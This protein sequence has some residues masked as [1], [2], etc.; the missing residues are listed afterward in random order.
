MAYTATHRHCRIAPRKVRLVID[1]IRGLDVASAMARL[2]FSPRRG[3]AQSP[4]QKRRMPMLAHSSSKKQRW[5]KVQSS[6]AFSRKTVG[7]HIQ[8]RSEHVIS[9]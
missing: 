4:M 6:S 7:A 1:M 5:T 9:M 2:D 8:S 3:A